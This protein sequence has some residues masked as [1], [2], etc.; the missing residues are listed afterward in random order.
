VVAT[1]APAGPAFE[2]AQ[3]RCGM[4]AAEGAI[5]GVKIAGG[6]LTLQVIGDVTPVGMCGSGLVDAVAE[7]V[8][9]GLIDA[10]GRFA[11]EPELLADRFGKIGEERVFYLAD[12]VYLS[13]R[14]V[15]ELQFAKASI[16]TGWNILL[17]ELGVEVGDVAQV[18]LAGSF[19]SYLSPA[20]AVRI[21]LVPKMAL[22]R[23]VSAGNMAGEGAKIAALS[24]QERAAASAIVDE[25]EYVEL[26]GRADFNDLFIDQLAFP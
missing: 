6:E 3:I 24:V 20:S 2:A 23:I 7:L 5:E 8:G 13:Q 16:A 4:R 22:A 26:S 21:G 12:D 1:A 14:D 18:L 17:R 10:S 9:V 11:L 15:R 19:G 25:V